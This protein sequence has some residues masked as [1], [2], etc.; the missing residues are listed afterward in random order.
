M[1]VKNKQSILCNLTL[2][3]INLHTLRADVD[4]ATVCN[5]TLCNI[6][7]GKSAFGD[8]VEYFVILHCVI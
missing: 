6:N 8:C 5:L 1:G 4:Y 7:K 3:N 2:C